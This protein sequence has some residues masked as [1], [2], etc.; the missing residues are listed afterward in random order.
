MDRNTVIGFILIGLI[1]IGFSILK[2]PSQEEIDK[3]K[4]YQDSIT[5]IQ[6]Q[7]VKEELASDTTPDIA[8]VETKVAE[9][10]ENT[11]VKSD[12]A[13]VTTTDSEQETL[14]DTQTPQLSEQILSLENEIVKLNFTTKGG[15]LLSAQLKDYKT[16]QG[17]SL[18]LF[19]SDAQFALEL[20]NKKGM[21][22]TTDQ[23]EFTPLTDKGSQTL[24][25]RMNYGENQYID[26]IYALSPNSYIIEFDV[27]IVGMQDILSKESA[28]ELKLKWV[29]KL[30]RQEKSEK[31]EQRYAHIHYKLKD[32]SVESLSDSSHDKQEISLPIKWV[33]FKD[34]Y[35]ATT[36]IAEDEFTI[37][38]MSSKMLNSQDYLKDYEADLYFKPEVK[39]GALTAS[40]KIFAGPLDYYML[41]GYDDGITDNRQKLEMDRLIPLGWSLFRAVNQ[42][43][44]IPLFNLL[45][46]T[47]MHVGIV[48]LLLTLIVKVILSPLTYKSFMSSAKMRVLKPQIEEITAKYPGQEKA[49][50]R[51]KA[52]MAL[53]NQAG[54]NPMSGCLPMLLQMPILIALFSFFPSAIELRQQS[55]LWASDL[56]TYDAIISWHANIPFISSLLDNHLSLF[57]VLMTATN[58]IYTKFN[59]DQTST[60]QEQMPG[61][62]WMMMLMPLVFFFV[63]NSYPSGLTYYYFLSTLITILITLSF[64]F[65]VDEDKVLAQ[66]EEN[67]KKPKK[68]GFMSRLQEQAEQAQR[69]QQQQAKKGGKGQNKKK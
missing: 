55:F 1:V 39:D 9:F 42:Y 36:F 16:Y 34:Q 31:N 69:Q 56:S 17:D 8:P 54:A 60:G 48:I 21:R 6:N 30:R 19:N 40:F 45:N 64:R 41:K 37:V 20:M 23:V 58:I 15:Q 25:M 12:S 44:I 46:S 57:C 32:G 49:M 22:F 35:F 29:Q 18:Y 59:M 38:D 7:Q 47:G 68:K 14:I 26:F 67:K 33:A 53:Y 24:I 10:F 27:A 62:K 50:E 2:K 51:Q 13:L 28:Q 43:F 65:F 52:T 11:P 66:L 5:A 4:R 63:L 3:Q 61:M